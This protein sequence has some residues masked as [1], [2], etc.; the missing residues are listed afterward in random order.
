MSNCVK[1]P[2]GNIWDAHSADTPPTT[3]PTSSPTTRVQNTTCR[4]KTANS[5]YPAYGICVA[6]MP[7]RSDDGS[8]VHFRGV[9]PRNEV[10][11]REVALPTP[12]N[13]ADPWSLGFTSRGAWSNLS[14]LSRNGRIPASGPRHRLSNTERG[15]TL[16]TRQVGPANRPPSRNRGDTERCGPR[17]HLHL[18]PCDVDIL[19]DEGR[20]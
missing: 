10:C 9:E 4:V 15:A 2:P 7:R 18:G 1:K 12:D 13:F 3:P 11:T 20:V 6:T 17:K 14:G 19:A 16:V 5:C 8:A